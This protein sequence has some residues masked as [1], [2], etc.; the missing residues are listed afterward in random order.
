MTTADQDTVTRHRLIGCLPLITLNL[1]VSVM[2]YAFSVICVSTLVWQSLVFG[3]DALGVVDAFRSQT[4]AWNSGDVLI[5]VEDFFDSTGENGVGKFNESIGYH[6]YSFDHQEKLYFYYGYTEGRVGDVKEPNKEAKIR[7]VAQRKA[8]SIRKGS[9]FVREFPNRQFPV[10][11]KNVDDVIAGMK[12][13]Y[14]HLRQIGFCSF[15]FHKPDCGRT[16]AAAMASGLGSQ[17]SATAA[18]KGIK[19][20]FELPARKSDIATVPELVPTLVWQWNDRQLVPE[21]LSLYESGVLRGRKF[22]NLRWT[23]EYRWGERDG[24]MIPLKIVQTTPGHVK[25]GE[26]ILSY[27]KTRLVQMHW[28]S[29]NQGAPDHVH[30]VELSDLKAMEMLAD[31]KIQNASGI[32]DSL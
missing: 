2:K 32:L 22:K 17:N 6:R 25:R 31:P 18:D 10:K 16:T 20:E 27:E 30:S 4:S 29:I 26:E 15:G 12:V 9:G 7:R 13:G 24:V 8:F 1:R 23:E 3:E 19:I 28:F 5:R 11:D 21:K 14:L